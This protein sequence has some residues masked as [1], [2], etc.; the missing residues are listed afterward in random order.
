MRKLQEFE[1][2]KKLVLDQHQEKVFASLPKP[3]LTNLDM[4]KKGGQPKAG[5]GEMR[6]I[7]LQESP[8]IEEADK[9]YLGLKNKERKEVLDKKLIEAYEETVNRSRS[10]TRRTTLAGLDSGFRFAE[11]PRETLSER[12]SK[13]EEEELK[14]RSLSGVSRIDDVEEGI[15]GERDLKSEKDDTKKEK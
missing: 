10:G 4:E 15:A 8:V 14:N 5:M 13:E 2:F 9:A 11:D 1:M 6:E 7:E 3:N 12:E